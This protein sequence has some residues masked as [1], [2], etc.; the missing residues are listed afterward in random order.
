MSLFFPLRHSCFEKAW[1]LVELPPKSTSLAQR[2]AWPL[3]CEK[4]RSVPRKAMTPR[5]VRRWTKAKALIPTKG[6]ASVTRCHSAT[7]AFASE[8]L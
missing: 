3:G 2:S 8:A 1:Q 7:V 4:L 6:F 5:R